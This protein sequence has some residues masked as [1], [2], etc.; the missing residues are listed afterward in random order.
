ATRRDRF[1]VRGACVINE[2]NEIALSPG[3][4]ARQLVWAFCGQGVQ[5]RGMGLELA[6]RCADFATAFQQVST[7]LLGHVGMSVET[8][9]THDAL[10]NTRFSQPAIFAVQYALA[11]TLSAWNVTPSAEMGPSN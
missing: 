2:T 7:C 11:Q 5:R 10:D 3:R 1:P 4:P 9:V 6:E 8:L